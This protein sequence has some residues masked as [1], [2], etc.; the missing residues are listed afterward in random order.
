M[1]DIA[2]PA[3]T[4]SS[5]ER[6]ETRPT[7]GVQA[8]P[9]AVA[10]RAAI[11][12]LPSVPPCRASAARSGCGIMPRTVL[13]SLK[14]PAILSRDPLGLS[15]SVG[16]PDR[17]DIP[18]GDPAFAVQPVNRFGVGEI[19][20]VMMG[21]GNADD[22]ARVVMGGEEGLAVLDPQID[23]PAEEFQ[24]G[25]AHQRPRQQT[26]LGQNLEAVANA[27]CRYAPF[28][29]RDDRPHYRRLRR[30]CAGPEVVA[31]GKSAGN[32]DHV[33]AGQVGFPMPDH[34]GFGAGRVLQRHRGVAVAV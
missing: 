22:L 2:V 15:S 32:D 11:I 18:E 4:R 25:I 31:I 21:D 12:G 10:A 5:L 1:F 29:L 24:A 27:Q 30:H 26:R 7:R 14:M 9:P 28:G 19:V 20:A 3:K 33:D 8:K 16:S 17:A 13:D 23:R 34:G 6:G